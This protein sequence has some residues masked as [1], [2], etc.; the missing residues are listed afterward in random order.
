VTVI[1]EL[2]PE[3]ESV[4]VAGLND[5]T[6]P[7]GTSEAQRETACEEP[8]T[9]RVKLAGP[10]SIDSV[11]EAD[12]ES[13]DTVEEEKSAETDMGVLTVSEQGLD[14]PEAAPPQPSKE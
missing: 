2:T 4:T 5:T 14:V 10:E 7:A 6:T 11:P 3:A 9:V 12:E 8:A 1:V 13:S